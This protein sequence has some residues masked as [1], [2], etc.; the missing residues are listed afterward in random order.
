MLIML[1]L[2][3]AL[4]HHQG[5]S[6]RSTQSADAQLRMVQERQW[7]MA[8]L[9][10]KIPSG[11][12]VPTGFQVSANL[13]V[14]NSTTTIANLSSAKMF[15]TDGTGGPWNGLPNV[16]VTRVKDADRGGNIS[17][18][19]GYRSLQGKPTVT[20]PAYDIF[21]KNYR[22]VVTDLSPYAAYAP[23]GNVTLKEVV[24]WS[25][26][27]MGEEWSTQAFSSTPTPVRNSG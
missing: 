21:P 6:R 26:P 10:N 3:S 8:R 24:G 2:V 19:P 4:H 13:A 23:A 9:L 14:T 7:E 15:Q 12:T 11:A 1:T 20:N 25:N 18:P 5:V 27:P 22:A 17:I 16:L